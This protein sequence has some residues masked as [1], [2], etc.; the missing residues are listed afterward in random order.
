MH[1]YAQLSAVRV[2]APTQE[3]RAAFVTIHIMRTQDAYKF[4]HVTVVRVR[5]RPM[6]S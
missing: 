5:P 3:G 2:I 4:A 1:R 6:R